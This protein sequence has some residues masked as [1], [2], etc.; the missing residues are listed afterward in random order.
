MSGYGYY[1]YCPDDATLQYLTSDK[2]QMVHL[3]NR[4]GKYVGTLTD[5]LIVSRAARHWRKETID[6]ARLFLVMVAE[7]FPEKLVK[8]EMPDLPEW[9]PLVLAQDGKK[10]KAK[11]RFIDGPLCGEH[12]I[13]REFLQYLLLHHK[14][15]FQEAWHLYRLELTPTVECGYYH[16]LS[17]DKETV[18]DYCVKNNIRCFFGA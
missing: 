13:C 17:G 6:A 2:P 12:Y 1:D 16:V 9:H 15:D 4:D 8:M 10:P 18:D 14:T 7:C 5:P 3:Y 11:V